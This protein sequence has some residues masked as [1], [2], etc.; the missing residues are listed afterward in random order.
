[1]AD[2]ELVRGG[3]GVVVVVLGDTEG[4]DGVGVTDAGAWVGEV[5]EAIGDFE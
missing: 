4:E 5:V 1:M 2:G 3:D